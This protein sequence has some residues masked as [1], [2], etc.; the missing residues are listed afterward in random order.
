MKRTGKELLGRNSSE[1]RYLSRYISIKVLAKYLY[2]INHPEE[3]EVLIVL[4]YL[5]L[6]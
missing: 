1:Q 6:S 5:S 4:F 2:S 3:P